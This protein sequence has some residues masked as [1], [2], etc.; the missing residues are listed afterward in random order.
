VA[1]VL[2]EKPA[3]GDFLAVADGGYALQYSPLL[4]YREGRGLVL[5]CQVD[6][7]GRTEADPAAETLA[8]NLLR[9]VADWKPGP[10]RRAV[11]VGDPAGRKHLASAGLDVGPYPQ[12]GPGG[13]Q[14]LIVG[15]GGGAELTGD[16]AALCR[17]V[18]DGG[19]LLALGVDA[20][21]LDGLLPGRV[22]MKKAEHI[23]ASFEPAGRSSPFAGI[24]PADVFNRDPREWPLVAKGAEVLG[25]GVLARAAG[26]NVVVCQVVPWAFDPAAAMNQ[27]RTF[28]RSACLVSRLAANLGVAASTPLLERFPRPVKDAKAEPRWREGLYLDVPEEWDDPYR[29]FRW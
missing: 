29:F 11:Y 7:T 23:A 12:G 9:Y 8:R 14:V 2:I 4:E 6:V 24:G 18:Q 22:A 1:S 19:R 25:D 27:K 28:R 13:D 10:G 15:R 21:D 20:G 3:R 5:F 26:G 16:Q 17:W